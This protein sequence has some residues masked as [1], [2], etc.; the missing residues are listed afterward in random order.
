MHAAVGVQGQPA[1]PGVGRERG[2]TRRCD[3]A[4]QQLGVGRLCH[5]GAQ[6]ATALLRAQVEPHFLWNTL[7]HV[8]YLVTS[9][10]HDAAAMTGH[11]IRYLRAAVPA[12]GAGGSIGSAIDSVRAYLEVMKIRMGARLES[13]CEAA[14]D[15][16][17]MPL[18]PLLLHTLVE[19]AIK[20]GIEPKTGPVSLCVSARR[21]PQAPD[22]VLLEVRDTGVGL[23]PAPLTRGSGLGLGSMRERLALQYGER[24]R[25]SVAACPAAGCWRASCCRCKRRRRHEKTA[26]QLPEERFVG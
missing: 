19:N 4:F 22:T 5:A 9:K 14:P 26:P 12:G 2:I 11:L 16:L 15:L 25:L 13:R 8:Q 7:A 3:A 21:D 10:P 1:L 17:D 18:A 23:Q 24:A 6:A 20:H